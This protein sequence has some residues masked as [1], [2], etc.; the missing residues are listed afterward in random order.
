MHSVQALGAQIRQFRKAQKS[1]ATDLAARSGVHRNTL[2]AL[3][4]GKGNIELSKLLAICSELGL[5]LV[6]LPQQ[7]TAQRVAE[8]V[9]APTEQAQRLQG[10][11][12]AGTRTA[13]DAL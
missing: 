13:G 6:L 8:Q 2:Q 12:V 1:S 5:E 10:L 3:E 9:S 7:A 4:T 11:V